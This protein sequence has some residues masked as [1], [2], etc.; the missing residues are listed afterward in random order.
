MITHSAIK[1]GA[2]V[3]SLVAPNRHH[4]VLRHI[5]FLL[6]PGHGIG[7]EGG[8]NVQGFLNDK[9]EFLDRE[10]AWLEAVDCKQLLARAP[11]DGKGGSLYS[12]DV[13]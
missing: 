7:G 1:L 9:G 5:A 12:E 3:Y 11:T 8:E 4:H 6:G 13:W 2:T 10:Q